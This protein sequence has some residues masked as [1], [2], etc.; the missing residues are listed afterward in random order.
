MCL[1]SGLGAIGLVGPDE[2]RYAAIAR[3]M[4]ETHDWVTPRLWGKPWFEKP[5]LY[6]WAAGAAMRLLGV[7]EFA[8]RLPSSLAALLAVL[9]AAWTALRSYGLGAAGYTLLMLPTSV[10]M[11]GFARAAGPDML[12]AAFL[13]AAMA[14]AVEMLQK[15][16]PGTLARI[17]F[18]FF[19]GAAVLAK[20]PAAIVLSGGATL[21][22][23][24][25]SRQWRAALQFFHPLIL[26]AFCVT[27]L[28]WYILCALRNPDFLRV[29]LWQHNFGR[30]LTPV[31]EHS[32]PFWFYAEI[33]LIAVL[34]WTFII[35]A[36]ARPRWK[37]GMWTGSPGL[38]FAC[39]TVFPLMFFSFSQSKLPGY[40]LPA[41]PPLILLAA[42]GIAKRLEQFHWSSMVGM[43]IT[44]LSF[45]LLAFLLVSVSATF[46]H[47]PLNVQGKHVY[48]A[49]AAA[50]AGL[51]I[52]TFSLIRRDKGAFFLAVLTIALLLEFA[53]RS[54]L[55]GLDSMYSARTVA[56]TVSAADPSGGGISVHQIP[57]AW[58][59]G[60]N[61]YMNRELPEWPDDSRQPHWLF[62]DSQFESVF[63]QKYG[64][65]LKAVS[66]TGNPF[67]LVLYE[68]PADA[69]A[70]LPH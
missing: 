13:T 60:L 41:I 24:A 19:L 58:H 23:A 61:Y 33:I 54:A 38:F 22:W 55:P 29:F 17:L 11:I 34:P 47:G 26:A 52:V 65:Q 57:R 3:A 5:A 31:F 20:G 39:W 68:F 69:V 1:F 28:P 42:V 45:V 70:A 49:L 51:G 67:K 44:G 7:S 62:A 56:Q 6:Y 40:V 25:F 64:L 16:R 21:L 9:A 18:G 32:Q 8:A 50:L 12:F 43:G 2:P 36:S 46:S 35:A 30:Y 27:A 59:Y 14:T 48:A 63:S 66:E 4:A 10:A 37:P 53:N 15:P